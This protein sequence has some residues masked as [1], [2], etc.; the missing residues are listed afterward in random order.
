MLT[1]L[2]SDVFLYIISFLSFQDLHNLYLLSRTCS[3]FITSHE[4][5]IFHQL[6]VAH[7]FV[8]PGTS[9]GDVPYPGLVSRTH[10]GDASQLRVGSWKELCTSRPSWL[11]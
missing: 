9:L 4:D 2:P 6:A 8:S 3:D 7:R 5:A 11:E 1:S 10:G